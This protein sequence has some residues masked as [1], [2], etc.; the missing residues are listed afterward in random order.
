[1][2]I[3]TTSSTGTGAITITPKAGQAITIPATADPTTDFIRINPQTSANSQQLLMTATDATTTWISSVNLLN[4]PV[5]PFVELKADFGGAI[6]KSIQIDADGA[7]SS[8]NRIT[9][10]DGQTNLPFQIDTSGYTNGSIEL[11]VNDGSGDLLLTSTNLQSGT[12]TGASGQ[13]LRIKINGTYYK[14]A[15][16][17]D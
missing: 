12:S 16:D 17:N 5:H 4:T 7:G 15:L 8:N 13:Y 14:I 10:Y 6:T 3:S 2:G 1:M 11:K 9:A